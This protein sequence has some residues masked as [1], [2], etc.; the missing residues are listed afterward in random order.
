MPGFRPVLLAIAAA[1]CVAAVSGALAQSLF[2]K[3][4]MPGPLIEGH[5]KLEKDCM[6][7]HE[8]FTRQSQSRLCLDCHKDIDRDRKERRGFHGRQ[9]NALAQDCRHC[10]SDHKGRTSDIVQLDRETFNHAVTNFELKGAHASVACDGCHK[11][12]IKFRNTPGRCVDCHKA[13]DR[14]KG[15]L[16]ES[17]DGC[18]GDKDWRTVKPFDHAKTKFALD[19]AHKNVACTACHAGE[20]YKGLA[21]NCNAC[22]AIQDRH[23]GRYGVKCETCHRPE[24]WSRIVFNHDR[25]TRFALRGQHARVKCDAC[26]TG[27]L[28]RDKL[29]MTC[30]SCHKKNDPH[31]GSLGSQCQN[32]HRETG[33]RTK[34]AFDHEATRF[35][36]IG[37]HAVVPC[38]ECHRSSNFKDTSRSCADCHKDDHHEGRLTKECGRCHNPNGWARWRFD[39]NV[40]TR[41]PLTGAH[42]G[43]QCHACHSEKQVAKVTART[44]CYACHG[45]DDI[46]Q[47][48]FGRACEQCHTTISFKQRVGRR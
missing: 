19:G 14:H 39:H 23:A 2:E 38:E 6:K 9:A 47:G 3:L 26:H 5:A 11:P 13:I 10:H 44:D 34:V 15:R 18:H 40:Q 25:A 17:C 36:L 46:H 24:K 48:S 32:C 7:C 35:P 28:Y 29:A 27:D 21:T 22:H 33:W 41:Y 42:Q 45:R 1:F 12:K 20:H 43:L 8:A 31:K 16:G 4:V 30:V 37:K